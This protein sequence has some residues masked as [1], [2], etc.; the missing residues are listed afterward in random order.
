MLD[1]AR[2]DQQIR[3]YLARYHVP[4][5]AVAVLKGERML[6]S[7]GFGITHIEEGSP[8]TTRT[9]FRV[10]SLTKVLTAVALL[11]LVDQ[12]Y[13]DLDVPIHSY[14]PELRFSRPDLA[15]VITLRMLM[16]H[17][18]GLPTDWEHQGTRD[19]DGLERHMREDIPHYVP[20]S[21]PGVMYHYSNPGMNIAGYIASK[22]SN[23]SFTTLMQDIVFDPLGM[24]HTTFDPLVAMTYPLALS[25]RLEHDRLLV[26]HAPVENT[27]H[28]PSGFAFSTVEDLS[29]FARMLLQKGRHQ[30]QQFLSRALVAEMQTPQ[31]PIGQDMPHHYGLPFVIGLYKGYRRIYHEGKIQ[32]YHATLEMFPDSGVAAIVLTNRISRRYTPFLLSSRLFEHLLVPD[33]PPRSSPLPLTGRFLSRQNGQVVLT[34]TDN[35]LVVRKDDDTP[36][37]SRLSSDL[38]EVERICIYDTDTVFVGLYRY[39][40]MYNPEPRPVSTSLGGRYQCH[41]TALELMVEDNRLL[42]QADMFGGLLFF[43][44]VGEYIFISETNITLRF[45]FQDESETPSGFLLGQMLRFR[46]IDTDW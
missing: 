27:A 43:Y 7:G 21:P 32:N 44:A 34:P 28:Y 9:L 36:S 12:R 38:T 26:E 20:H 31:I 39:D 29:I 17:L 30:N 1:I 18:A 14:T 5:M 45:V 6:Y 25:H 11:R 33:S 4:A 40:R 10:G 15:Q 42:A 24:H 23:L 37:N 35:G 13:L 19:P 2:L 8:V 3:D 16:S 41:N 46:R 22:I